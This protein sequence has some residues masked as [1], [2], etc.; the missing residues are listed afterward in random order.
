MDLISLL[1]LVVVLGLV[2]WLCIFVID[3][4]PLPSP[5]GNVAKAIVGLI[6]ILILLSQIGF[7]GGDW[8]HRPLLR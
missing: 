6:I 7:L 8:M 3:Q 1:I 2:F 4:L 5:F